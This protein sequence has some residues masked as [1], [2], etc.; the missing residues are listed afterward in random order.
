MKAKNIEKELDRE[1]KSFVKKFE[2][3]VILTEAYGETASVKRKERFSKKVDKRYG[4]RVD[5]LEQRID[6]LDSL[7]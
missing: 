6:K 3:V 4:K 2:R 1:L 5:E 7:F